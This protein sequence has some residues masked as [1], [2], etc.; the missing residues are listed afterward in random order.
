MENRCGT[1]AGLLV[2]TTDDN[3][4]MA[5]AATSIDAV[6]RFKTEISQ[7]FDITDLGEIHWFLSFEIRHDRVARTIS[8]TRELHQSYGRQIWTDE[9]QTLYTSRCFLEKYF[10][11]TNLRHSESALRNA[12]RALC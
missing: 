5:I 6:R 12:E 8:I 9:R 10:H 4:D 7:F 1:L 11:G 3:H 2:P